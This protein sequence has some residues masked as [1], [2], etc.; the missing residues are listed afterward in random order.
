MIDVVDKITRSRMM[1]GIR[2]KDTG[3]ELALRH[4]LHR[5]G[6]RY[7]L[8]VS[9]L[10]GRPDLVLP[11][12]GAV[13]LVHGCFWHRHRGCAFATTPSSNGEFW[14]KKFRET[15]LRDRRNVKRLLRDGW[16]IATVWEC[17]IRADRTVGIAKAI[18]KWLRSKSMTIELPERRARLGARQDTKRAG[19]SPSIRL[20]KGKSMLTK[21]KGAG[22]DAGP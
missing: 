7:R 20:C 2:G 5:L 11:R 16:R 12:Y 8:H 4:A 21:K 10:H 22:L 14:E 13:V 17:E 6:L 1:S 19:S 3:P 15:V 9:G 18:K